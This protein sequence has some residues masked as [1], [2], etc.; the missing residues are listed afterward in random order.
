MRLREITTFIDD[1]PDS[2]ACSCAIAIGVM[3]CKRAAPDKSQSVNGASVKL[4]S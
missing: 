1:L 3:K 2:L 4:V